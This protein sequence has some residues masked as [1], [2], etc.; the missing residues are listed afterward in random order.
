MGVIRKSNSPF[1][2][3]IPLQEFGFIQ[4]YFIRGLKLNFFEK[5]K[6]ILSLKFCVLQYYN[7]KK[8]NIQITNFVH[9]YTVKY[10]RGVN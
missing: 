3:G 2:V 5:K 7:V 9:I 1:V 8:Q 4:Y 10:H 6:T